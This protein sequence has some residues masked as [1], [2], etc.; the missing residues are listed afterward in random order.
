MLALKFF[1]ASLIPRPQDRPRR[2]SPG[3]LRPRLAGRMFIP[4]IHHPH[5]L[6]P[7]S[8]RTLATARERCALLFL[9]QSGC[10][11]NLAQFLL[12]HIAQQKHRALPFAQSLHRRPT[13]RSPAPA[14]A[15]AVPRTLTARQ[16][17]AGFIQIHRIGSRRPPELHPPVAPVVLLQVDR[18]PHQPCHGARLAP[19]TSPV[20]VRLQGHP[21]S[22]SLRD[23]HRAST[24]KN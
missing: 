4:L 20:T 21:G 15:A 18:N 9:A 3:P 6:P 14:P 2:I 12:F 19:E 10:P 23:P 16:P 22:A 11:R 5:R 7:S 17:F 1:S 13:P 8:A 24:Q